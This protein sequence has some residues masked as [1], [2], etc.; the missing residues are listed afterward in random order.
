MWV[1]SLWP[2]SML[3]PSPLPHDPKYLNWQENS[4][5]GGPESSRGSPRCGAYSRLYPH[6][7]LK[8]DLT[9]TS[10]GGDGE[11]HG[12]R[13]GFSRAERRGRRASAAVAPRWDLPAA[14]FAAERG[15][16]L[17]AIAWRTMW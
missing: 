4:S 10:P 5:V 2:W 3:D 7:I 6:D 15:T 17:P 13:R 8:S 14:A 11:R 12:L 9:K 16:P 1:K